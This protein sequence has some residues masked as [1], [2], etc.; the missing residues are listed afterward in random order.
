MAAIGGTTVC[1]RGLMHCP[2]LPE[3]HREPERSLGDAT[4]IRPAIHRLG[5]GER[6]LVL[7]Q[8]AE[9]ERRGLVAALVGAPDMPPGPRPVHPGPRA[10]RRD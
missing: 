4:L 2:S 7:E 5:I 6:T 10:E 1:V 9:I 8:N 3:Q